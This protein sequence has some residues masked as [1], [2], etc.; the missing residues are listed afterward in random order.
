MADTTNRVFND[1]IINAQE[2]LQLC[3][4]GKTDFAQGILFSVRTKLKELSGDL[5]LSGRGRATDEANGSHFATQTFAEAK[6]W[7]WLELAS[8]VLQLVRAR[9]GASMVHF[10]RA[11]RIWRPWSKGAES[12]EKLEAMRERIRASLWSGE[13]WARFSSDRAERAANAIVRAAFSELSHID[14]GDL[15]R[16]TIEQQLLLPPAPTGTPAYRA[17]GSSIPYVMRFIE[18]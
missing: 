17:S 3:L 10:S 2:A 4:E 8:G 7:G 11:W 18:M 6:A 1:A 14:A 9:P 16:V 5:P 15:L 12:A 13:A